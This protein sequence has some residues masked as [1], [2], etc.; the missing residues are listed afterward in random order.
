MITMIA[1][2]LW[3]FVAVEAL[4]LATNWISCQ[5]TGDSQFFGIPAL[6]LAIALIM[7][8]LLPISKFH[9]LWITPLA[10]IIPVTIMQ[11]RFRLLIK[12]WGKKHR[13]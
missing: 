12:S 6:I 5:K 4:F 2:A 11:W 10:A 13:E 3:G 8:G 7:T 9:L 1:W